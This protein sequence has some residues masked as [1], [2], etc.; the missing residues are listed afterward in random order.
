MGEN[1]PGEPPDAR[2]RHPRAGTLVDEV[3]GL[4]SATE[5]SVRDHAPQAMERIA[6]HCWKDL[7]NTTRTQRLLANNLIRVYFNVGQG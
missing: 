1:F 6:P 4:L 3:M 5:T 7:E 2:R